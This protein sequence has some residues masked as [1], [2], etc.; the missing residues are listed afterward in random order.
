MPRRSR[1]SVSPYFDCT[2]HNVRRAWSRWR[3][4]GASGQVLEWIRHGVSIPW[5][6]GAPPPPFNHGVSCRNLPPQQAAFLE[7]EIK[8]L[9]EK[10]VFRPVAS[11]RWVSRAFLVPK[12]DGSWRLIIDLRQ[13]N[14]YCKQ[15]SM[16]ME[17]LRRLKF[18]AKPGDHWISFDLKDG[19]YA[20]AIAPK[21]R[22]AFSVNLNGEL[23]QL[24]ALPMGWC[25]SPYTF[26]KFTNVFI[27]NL[28]D[29]G[30]STA[31]DGAPSILSPKAR[32]RWLRR[33]RRL[34]GA[35]ILPFVDDFAVFANSFDEAQQRRDQV[36]TLLHDL[37]LSVHETK[38]HHTPVQVGE[39]LGMT[40]DFEKGEFRAPPKKLEDI[41][42]LA[43][44]ILYRAAAHRR[45]ISVKTLASL[46]GKAQ[47]LHLAIPAA[48]FYLRE[49]H[50]VVGSATSWSGTVKISKQ[51]KRDLEWWT[52]VPSRHN[53]APIWKPVE[54]AY[55]HCDS[56]SFGWGA[57]LNDCLEARGVWTGG[58]RQEHITYKELKAV[59]LAIKSFLPELRGRRL[60]LH[61]D[62][63]SV[64][65]V[66]TNL[67][68]RSPT[69]MNELRKLFLLTDTNDVKIRVAYIRSA[70]NIWADKLSRIEDNAD[71]QLAPR[72]FRFLDKQWGPHSVDRFASF[73]NKQLPRY[74][75]RWRDGTSEA[76]D[77]LH[78]PDSAWRQET[79]WCN[80]PWNLLDDLVAKLRQSRAAATVVAPL[81][82]RCPWFTHLSEMASET[83]EMPPSRGL[84]FPRGQQ[85]LGGA[86]PSAWGV[87]AFKLPLQHG[88]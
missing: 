63:Q 85:E 13:L 7:D 18:I 46:T 83:V 62:N 82:P 84:F 1:D 71:W 80:P 12:P 56:S 21:D 2:R 75:A 37:G 79:N 76:V 54:T 34:T 81:W 43:K 40:L 78:L 39:H 58:D 38:G 70:A 20:L 25:L 50:D 44:Q 55:L 42:S 10:G 67:T 68:S 22:E 14:S 3:D 31:P 33:R 86:G 73:A 69:M 6:Y 15:R 51:L 59:R 30:T 35:R 29:P 26:Q 64:V 60:L 53:G 19:F 5:L 57:V 61:E 9:K 77:S 65:G 32:K 48:K 8:R 28:R 87:V 17:T 27:H 24:C 4:A 49:A 23:L 11:S 74:N 52:Q 36:F 16:K 72:V 47:F 88:C 45:W 66:L 41:A